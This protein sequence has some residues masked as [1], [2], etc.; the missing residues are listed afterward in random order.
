MVNND[1]LCAVKAV[2]CSRFYSHRNSNPLL[3][4]MG[5]LCDEHDGRERH[6]YEININLTRVVINAIICKLATKVIII[7][8]YY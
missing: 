3:G 2:Y 8:N 4:T 5:I 1:S 7:I 6:F